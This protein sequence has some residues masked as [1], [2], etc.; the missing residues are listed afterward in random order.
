MAAPARATNPATSMVACSPVMKAAW[1][2]AVMASASR[3]GAPAGTGASPCATTAPSRSSRSVNAC[4][5]P[6]VVRAGFRAAVTEAARIEPHTAVPR[7][8]PSWMEVVWIP[9]ATP[10][11]SSEMSP[12]IAS[13]ADVTTSPMPRTQQHEGRPQV[14][15]RGVRLEGDEG[16]DGE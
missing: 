3:A 4:G 6:R 9:P 10:A 14:A 2:P 13:V 8:P 12:T 16:E 7:T 1:L 5:T 15:V 11:S